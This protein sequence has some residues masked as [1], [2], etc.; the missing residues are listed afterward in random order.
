MARWSA[1]LNQPQIQVR[2]VSALIVALPVL[3]AVYFGTPY[4]QLLILLCGGIAAWEWARLCGGGVLDW[5]GWLLVAAVLGVLLSGAYGYYGTAIWAA[6]A[7]AIA[8][9]LSRLIRR[10]GAAGWHALGV[11]YVSL[12]GLSVM[13]LRQFGE[14]RNML[15]SVAT[16]P[17]GP[18]RK[19]LT[20]H[21][22]PGSAWSRNRAS[23]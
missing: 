14:V 2:V 1:R 12:A 21:C 19:E 17:T 8:S 16:F 15:W 20:R 13:W 18:C 3:A 5:T 11:L 10:S 23:I 7:A 22:V 6:G 9:G 4:L